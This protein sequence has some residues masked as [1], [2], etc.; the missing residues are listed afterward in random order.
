MKTRFKRHYIL[1]MPGLL[2]LAFS[3]S[4]CT[5]I[6]EVPKP[7]NEIQISEAFADSASATGTVTGI[8]AE[9]INNTDFEWG[10][11]TLNTSKSADDIQKSTADAFQLNTLSSAEAGISNMWANPYKTLLTIN[12][13]LEG[14]KA[15]THL[16][17]TVKN[18]LQGE[19]YFSRAFINFYLVNLWG[20]AAPMILTS[21]F[22]ENNGAA[23]TRSAT[24]YAQIV[25][26]LKQAQLLMTNAYPTVNHAR[27]NLQAVNALLARVY[28]YTGK[29]TDAVTQASAVIGSGL[30]TLPAP[31]VAFLA[32]SNETIWC[33]Q[34]NSPYYPGVTPDGNTFPPLFSF[35][36]PSHTLTTSLADAFETGDLR[37]TNWT[38]TSTVSKVAY[39]YPYKYKKNNFN[40]VA[41]AENYVMLR[42]AEQYLI[43]A[44]AYCR[45]GDF[46]EAVTDL[47]VVRTRAGLSALSAPSTTAACMALIEQECRVE[48][49]AEWG[50]R[51]FDLKRWPATDGGN[52]TRAD[53]VL[54]ALKPTWQSFQKL[55]PVP[56]QQLIY[57][58][59]LIQN[60]GY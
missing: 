16:S 40:R 6:L 19:C 46:A 57:D 29:Y 27:P 23:S 22:V 2:G 10:G 42:L 44:E 18:H 4:N 54:S 55:Y 56:R 39:T 41:A 33:I 52:T 5:K 60:P 7:P 48:F 35:I 47:N 58:R 13:A 36:A 45:L 8:Y 20:N 34:P 43:R 51:W 38:K 28:L 1:L 30:Y 15:S 14:L 50:H 21:N 49:F 26:D 24:A 37:K 9:E 11:L 12:T 17:S 59:N 31:D 3:L 53:Q 32:T 25:S